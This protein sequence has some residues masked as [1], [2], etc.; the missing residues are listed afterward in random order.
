LTIGGITPPREFVFM[1]RVVIGRG[2][3]YLRLKAEF[4]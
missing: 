2:S 3:V 4:S 1:D